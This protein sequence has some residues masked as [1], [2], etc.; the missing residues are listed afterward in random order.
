MYSKEIK[1][2][3]NYIKNKVKD[4]EIYISKEK[5]FSVKIH[6]QKIESFSYS[7]SNGIGLRIIQNNKIGYSYTE[8]FE[9]KSLENIVDEAIKNSELTESNKYVE[10]KN[11]PE[12]E[13]K[14]EV[15]SKKIEELDI[16]DKINFAM[17]LEKLAKKEDTRVIN[18]PYAIFGN[19]S[20]YTKIVNSK[21][22]NKE[23]KH[24]SAY[25]F[26]GV[27]ASESKEN[28][29]GLEFQIGRNFNKF[30]AKKLAQDSV[31][32][33]T[34]LLNSKPVH[35]SSYAIVFNEEMMATLL[36]TFSG[37]FSA[38]SIQ[39]GKSILSGKLG[40]KIANNKVTIID[41][42]LHPDG[43]ATQA[44]DSEGYPSQKTILVEKGRLNSYLHNTET[45]KKDKVKS[46]GNGTRSYKDS[47]SV[48]PTNLYL[49]P[50]SNSVD[51][52]FK[53]HEETI[54]IVNLQGL[55]S[56]ANPISGDFSLSGEGYLYKNG[57][58]Q[59][60]LKPFTVSGNFLNML[61]D[62]EMVA[63]NFRF[64]MNSVGAA[65]VLIKNL[66]ISG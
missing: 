13:N 25:S 56:G 29:M 50:N 48:S 1:I 57:K 28:R 21:G 5:T 33:A 26:V 30:D 19:T 43:Y 39:E 3:E 44:F 4:F 49:E 12:L 7:D 14:P 46:T 40:E 63:N 62:V 51:E 27:L 64:N 65:S 61:N 18:V 8:K 53:K 22:L 47:L 59:H 60:S 2:I 17:E 23:D 42:A 58:K 31:R 6:E 11:Y 16:K 10:I 20:I 41:N 24:N 9:K 55:H 34:G 35:S 36:K 66:S 52:L 45:A 38:E 54:E 32:K 37:M 15:Y